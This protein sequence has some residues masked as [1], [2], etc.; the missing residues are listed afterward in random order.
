MKN[1]DRIAGYEAEKKELEVLVDIFNN[2]TKY[3]EKGASL[4]KGIIFY[5]EAGTG[6]TLFSQVLAA[7]CSLKIITVDVAK[8][9]KTNDICR[10]VRKAFIKGARSHYPTMMC[11]IQKM[12]GTLRFLISYLS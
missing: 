2:R 8:A 6:K 4:P 11:C 5:G 3:R 10:L 12:T 7:E 1:F 9:I